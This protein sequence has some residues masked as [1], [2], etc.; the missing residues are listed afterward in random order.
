MLSTTYVTGLPHDLIGVVHY[1]EHTSIL[2]VD[3]TWHRLVTTTA[4]DRTDASGV[5]GRH[6]VVDT[7]VDTLH[8]TVEGQ[9]DLP[10][11]GLAA[12][13]DITVLAR[14]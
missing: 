5:E 9:G 10:R 12:T 8:P 7:V 2:K 14:M 11:E 6:D 13:G 3:P 1:D 4:C